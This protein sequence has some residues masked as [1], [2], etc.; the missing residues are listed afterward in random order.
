MA[1]KTRDGIKLSTIVNMV[2]ELGIAVRE[3]TKH[4]YILQAPGLRPCPVAESTDARS[5]LAPWIRNATGY[6]VRDIYQS[7]RQGEWYYQAVA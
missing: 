2:M 6:S 5:M 3:G 7:L 4:P 1:G